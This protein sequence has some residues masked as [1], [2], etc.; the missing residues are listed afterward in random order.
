GKIRGA[1]LS[2]P[3]AGQGL[4]LITPGKKGELLGIFAA[5]RRQPFDRSCDRL[6]PLNFAKLAG[7]A[8]A[9]SLERLS[10]LRRRTLLHDAGSALAADHAAVHRMVAVAF[11]I[12]NA[13]IR[14]MNLNP[15]TALA[16]VAGR[17]LDL[18]RNLW[19]GIDLF[20][21]QEIIV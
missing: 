9:H 17:V 14:Q 21:R 20:A 1:E 7:A 15:A 11:D 18:V 2:S 5:D 12:T 6:L 16:H 13:A 3:I 10:Q 19:R 4:A 8:L